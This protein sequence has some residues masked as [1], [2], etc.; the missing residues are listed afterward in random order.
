MDESWE[1]LGNDLVVWILFVCMEQIRTM[2]D[3]S[4]IVA[5]P[6]LKVIITTDNE[7]Y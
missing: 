2:L 1:S 5:R 7:A 6:K 3:P 4:I